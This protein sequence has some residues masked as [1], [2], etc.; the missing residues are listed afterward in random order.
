MRKPLLLFFTF[1]QL[2]TYAQSVV[3]NEVMTSNNTIY[4]D[5]DGDHKDWIELYNNGGTAID[6]SGYYLSDDTLEF[7]QWQFPSVELQPG[8]FV[9]VFASGKNRYGNVLHTNF[10][11][12][13]S[14]ETVLLSDPQGNRIDLLQAVTLLT[15]NS[16]GRLRDGQ[17]Q[18]F[19][20]HQPT[21][22]SSNEQVS[23]PS[24]SNDG[25]VYG[26][27]FD[28]LLVARPGD[29][30][31]YTIDGSDPQPNSLLYEG[32]FSIADALNSQQDISNIPT[33]YYWSEPGI[34][35]DRAV[36]IKAA[37]F[38]NG[39]RQ[40][41]IATHTY[42]LEDTTSTSIAVISIVV[43]NAYLFSEDSGIYVP[44]INFDANN[45]E[46]T[47]NF[48]E[49]GMD[50]EVPAHMEFYET[51]GTIGFAQKVGL[52]I[53][54][55]KSRS[56]PQKSLRVY[57][58]EEYGVSKIRHQVFPQYESDEYKRLV[59]RNSF[60]SWSHALIEDYVASRVVEELDIDYQAQRLAEVYINGEYWGVHFITERQDKHYLDT[61]HEIDKENIDL[62]SSYTW[63]DEGDKEDFEALMDYVHTYDLSEEQHYNYITAHIDLM[64]F[65][66]YYIAEIFLANYDWPGNNLKM[67]KPKAPG[68]QWRWMFFDLDA[69]MHNLYQHNL[70]A[71]QAAENTEWPNFDG[72]TVF[73]RNMMQ[74]E[75]FK[76]LFFTRLEELANTTFHPARVNGIINA[77]Q[78]ALAPEIEKHVE[79]WTHPWSYDTWNEAIE[80]MRTFAN[81]RPCVMAAQI[82]DEY[83][84]LIN[85]PNCSGPEIEVTKMKVFPNPNDGNFNLSFDIND[86]ALF[87]VELVTVTGQV[88]ALDRV[89]AFEGYNRLEFSTNTLPPGFYIVRLVHEEGVFSTRMILSR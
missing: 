37:I 73:F 85:V 41:E 42:F 88:M 36:V 10:S 75:T 1:C 47:G 38:N 6:L 65:V 26:T 64:N 89:Q 79:R 81:D 46:W 11:L 67:W 54:G 72:S 22:G 53:Q 57:A 62:I 68:S 31:R 7:D 5:E 29:T 50:W 16:Y 82:L 49:K 86:N 43:D 13:S 71:A 8:E 74:N 83:N 48:F 14:G 69:S 18:W 80:E 32:A 28:L 19:Y 4:A 40:G 12:K 15:D 56:A 87:N 24:F 20:I 27:D 25:G 76:V 66:D 59:L 35:H 44:G 23:I 70:L 84:F 78:R 9:V 21:P 61:H 63:A 60:G 30:I 58:R 55:G 17:D 3:I 34:V 45:P 33:S 52:R 77:T 39:I 2:I 51:D